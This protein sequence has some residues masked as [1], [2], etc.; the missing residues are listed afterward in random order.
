MTQNEIIFGKYK[1]SEKY[2]QHIFGDE[3]RGVEIESNNPVLAVSI[4]IESVPAAEFLARFELIAEKLKQVD[5]PFGTAILDCGEHEVQAVVIQE[6]SEGQTLAE[7]LVDSDGLPENLVL[8]IA[9][10]VGGFLSDLHR[11]NLVHGSL[12]PDTILLTSKGTVQVRDAGL[13]QGMNLDQLLADGKIEASPIHAPELRLGG[14]LNPAVDFYA[15]GATLF[16]LLTGEKLALEPADIWPGNKKQGISPELDELVFKCLQSDPNRRMQSAAELLNGIAETRRGSQAG[17]QDTI[18]GMEDALVGHTLGNYQLVERLGQGGMATVYKAYEP[19]LD[20]YVAIKVLPQFF[21]RDPNFMNRFR[22]EAKAVAQLNHP[23]IMPIYSFGEEGDITYIAMQYVPGGTLKQGRGQEYEPEEAI[24]LAL[25]IV[26]ALAYAHGRGIVHRDIKPSN[27]LL[28]ED[29]WPVLAD[30]GLAKMAEASQK[31]TGTGVGVGTPMYMSPEQGQGAGVD[32]RTDIYSTGIMLYEM[33]TGDVPFRADTPMAVVIKHMTAPLPMP[34]DANPNIPEA[35]ERIILKATAKSQDDRYQTAEEMIAALE[36]VQNSLLAPARDVEAAEV[37]VPSLRKPEIPP[38]PK[39]TTPIKKVG[40]IL[41]GIIGVLLLGVILMWIFDICPPDGPWPIPPWCPGST[42]K[43]PTI[44]GGEETAPEITEGALG[45]ILFQDDFEGEISSRWQFSSIPGLIPWSVEVIDGRTVMHSIPHDS[46]D[47]VSGAEIRD[48]NWENYAIQYDFRFA[49]PDQFGVYYYV[50]EGQITDCPP[51]ISSLQAYNLTVSSDKVILKKSQCS[52]SGDQTLAE[53][54][55]DIDPNDW[56]TLQYIFIGNRIQ[57]IIDGDSYIDF[58]DQDNPIVGGG[59]LWFS[60]YGGAEIN[61][62]HLKVYDVI[63]GEGDDSESSLSGADPADSGLGQVEGVGPGQVLSLDGNGSYVEIPYS[64]NL[65]LS[66][67]LTLEAWINVDFFEGQCDQAQCDFS[68]IIS[69]G[70]SGSS[71]GN[72]TL[73][74]SLGH[75]GFGFEPIDSRY[76][77]PAQFKTGWNH[78]AVTH[79]F[80]RGQESR[81]Y[82][83]GE[84]LSGGQWEDDFG[85][86]IDGDAPKEPNTGSPYWIGRLGVEDYYFSGEIDEVRIWE[87]V[88]TQEEIQQTMY[89]ELSGDEE[90]LVAN[91]QMDEGDNTAKILGSAGV[92]GI[93][94]GNAQIFE[95]QSPIQSYG[96]AADSGSEVNVITKTYADDFEDGFADFWNGSSV[97]FWR[98]EDIDG[99]QVALG[100][101]SLGILD[102]T[103]EIE[104]F[105]F[106]VDFRYAEPPPG[107]EVSGASIVFRQGECSWYHLEIFS[108]GSGLLKQT[109]SSD[110]V[111]VEGGFELPNAINPG[112]WH[113]VRISMVG[114]E[115]KIWI[116]GELMQDF[117]DKGEPITAGGFWISG[118]EHEDSTYYDNFSLDVLGT[119]SANELFVDS[120]Q[121]LGER[122]T[123]SIAAGD[124]DGDGDIDI[125]AGNSGQTN[126]VWTNAGG[127]LFI[128]GFETGQQDDTYDVSPGDYDGDGDL[129]L[130][131]INWSGVSYVLTNGGQGG[132]EQTQTLM[133]EDGFAEGWGG[134]SGDLDGDGDL[135]VWMVRGSNYVWIN[136]GSGMFSHSGIEYAGA[137][138]VGVALGDLDGDG[139]LDAFVAN[140]EGGANFV[141]M[142]QGNGTFIDSG[143]RL[144]NLPSNAVA[145]GD[146]DGDGDLDAFVANLEDQPNTV[147]LNNGGGVFVDSGQRLDQLTSNAVALG[148]LDNDGDL[149]AYVVNGKID[150]GEPKSNTIYL[151]NGSGNFSE[152]EHVANL[153]ISTDVVLLD[154]NNDGWLDI[155]EATT[156]TILVYFSQGSTGIT[157]AESAAP[158]KEWDGYED[159]WGVVKISPG[160]S[161]VLGVAA[162][163]SGVA[164][165]IGQDQFDAIQLAVSDY[166]QIAGFPIEIINV[167]STCSPEGGKAA[168]DELMKTE[169]LAA[170]VGTTCSSALREAMWIWDQ[171]HIVFIS[172]SASLGELS[173]HGID[174]FNRT[175][176]SMDVNPGDEPP[177]DPNSAGYQTFSASFEAA[178]GRECCVDYAAEA[179]DA[180]MILLHAIEAVSEIDSNGQLLIPRQWLASTVRDTSRYPGVSGNISFDVNGDR[181]M[182]E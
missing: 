53:S 164:R 37:T 12:G 35:L 147:W 87:I 33:L 81:F 34:R 15:L 40:L 65:N 162:D 149:D 128:Q 141:Y 75:V 21:A 118:Y 30:F 169:N 74:V 151:N 179:Y 18:L 24:R 5:S 138:S 92:D 13:A 3:Y 67:S 41:G 181:I 161:I 86:V 124:V 126:L 98:I 111:L 114:N 23:S 68:A 39:K 115:I 150:A 70:H 32:H 93:L 22:R 148:D 112:E 140:Y 102:D 20:R 96:F 10:Q 19:A 82:L 31:L 56:H 160:D 66:D 72:Y 100:S 117:V 153:T 104:D 165:D 175:M 122:N 134:A 25:P 78:V 49:Q 9:Q 80:G 48:T 84:S 163:L 94:R 43:L 143:Q 62:D 113:N 180:A 27:V 178:Y 172:P 158:A 38:P 17:A 177:A 58:V 120:G 132:F 50:I 108:N 157:F 133:T 152:I 105:D 156:E 116:D 26:R 109:C 36:R 171:A 144:G 170:I 55:R 90:G 121:R 28:G 91:L 45:S 155:V 54:D 85:G 125:I 76:V 176:Y 46:Q 11:A 61:V 64:E 42:Y 97:S 77:A 137:D 119:V 173:T 136:D 73:W 60:I 139:D 14:E 131:L 59:D 182:E 129:D 110:S 135:D 107:E 29:D 146:L 174:V 166:G 8:D 52:E 2:R 168:A 154:L 127:G 142:N 69:Q 63:L 44:G 7:M 95:S 159:P 51:T 89:S 123:R 57:V 79:T 106:N 130:F 101:D 1:F 103:F 47:Q 4:K 167:D 88:R 16:E 145:L 99:N 71:M 6:I 83:N